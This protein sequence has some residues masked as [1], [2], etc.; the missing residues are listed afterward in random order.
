MN[1]FRNRVDAGQQLV[2][3]LRAYHERDNT[4]VLALP[5]GGVPVAAQIARTLKLPLDVWVVRKLGAPDQPELAMG[6]IA[7]GGAVVMNS[8]VQAQFADQPDLIAKIAEREQQELQRRELA[9]RGER[10][11]LTIKDCI[12]I[13]VDDGAATG[14]TMR[15]AVQALQASRPKH[16]V[17]ALPVC[18]V[19]AQSMLEEE[20]DEVICLNVPRTFFAVGQWY[21][22]FDQTTDEEVC[23]LLKE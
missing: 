7:S 17:V 15:A 4:I 1:V 6:A 3:K 13:I 19:E 23:R 22:E 12:T 18:S 10:G 8:E 20:A 11:P 2:R 5:R 16:I 21:E 14:A 9:Y